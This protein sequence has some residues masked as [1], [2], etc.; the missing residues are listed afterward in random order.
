MAKKIKVAPLAGAWIEICVFIPPSDAIVVAPL[1][2]AW[3]EI[4]LISSL[5]FHV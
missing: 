2:G 5:L 3:I 1:A 4:L